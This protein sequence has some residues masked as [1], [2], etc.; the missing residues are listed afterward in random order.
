M[1]KKTPKKQRSTIFDSWVTSL[2]LRPLALI[3]LKL[4]G[5]KDDDIVKKSRKYVLIVAPHTSNWDFLYGMLFSLKIRI[6]HAYVI[7]K[8]SIVNNPFG[9]VTKWLGFLPVDR[10]RSQNT[11]AKVA[12]LMQNMD[13]IFLVIAPEGTRRKVQEWKTGF[14]HIASKA[15]VPI[16][17]GYVDYKRK[18][19]G[20]TKEFTPTGDI[21]AD[22]VAIKQCYASVTSHRSLHL[23]KN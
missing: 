5:W 12:A 4:L 7:G 17:L 2:L 8:D 10:S 21:D 9:F 18:M 3:L 1:N 11:V 15:K 19:V 20:F 6:R 23:A 13:D 16:L 14:Y 22:M